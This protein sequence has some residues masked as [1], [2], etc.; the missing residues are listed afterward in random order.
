MTTSLAPKLGSACGGRAMPEATPSVHSLAACAPIWASAQETRL[1]RDVSVPPLF[2]R[3]NGIKQPLGR[4][5]LFSPLLR[6]LVV[7]PLAFQGCA[8]GLDMV[9]SRIIV[10]EHGLSRVMVSRYND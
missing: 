2:Y 1:A 3:S 7:T 9:L 8:E 4:F 6:Y 5:S 10:F